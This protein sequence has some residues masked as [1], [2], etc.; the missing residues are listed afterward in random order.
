MNAVRSP[1]LVLNYTRIGSC[2]TRA[3]EPRELA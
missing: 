2:G 3:S 1:A